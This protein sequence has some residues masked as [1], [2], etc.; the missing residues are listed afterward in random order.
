[1]TFIKGSDFSKNSVEGCDDR[2]TEALLN[3]PWKNDLY[4]LSLDFTV[5]CGVMV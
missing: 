1:M 4:S 3:I 5:G 2:D